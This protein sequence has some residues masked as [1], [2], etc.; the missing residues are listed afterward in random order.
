M[1]TRNAFSGFL[2]HEANQ[3]RSR[4]D[5]LPKSSEGWNTVQQSQSK[6]AFLKNLLR[7]FGFPLAAGAVMV[8]AFFLLQAQVVKEIR[9]GTYQILMDAARQ[10]SNELERYVD[11][12]TTRVHLIASYD[13]DTGPNTLVE[14]LR[15]E[16]GNEVKN[17]G[18][19][20]A[21]STGYLLYSDQEDRFVGAEDWFVDSLAGQTTVST[22]TQN[23]LDG[24]LGVRVST[25]VVTQAGTEGVL[26]ATLGNQNFSDLLRTLAYEG[27][28]NTF[29]SDEN[30]VILF[31]EN[32]MSMVHVGERIRSYI[33]DSAL[34]NGVTFDQLKEQLMEGKIV[35]FHFKAS[36][37]IYYA[38]CERIVAYNWYV[39]TLVPGGIADAI[40]WRVSEYQIIMLLII[41]LVGAT[42]ATQSYRHE[43]ETVAKL[44]ADKDLL[45]Q[46]AQRY[47]LIT[48]LSN[49]VFFHVL[50]DTG[51]IS[52]NDTFESMFGFPA[53]ACSID[54]PEG[55]EKLFFEGDKEIFLRLINHL[56]A[57]G[58]EAHVELR[59]INSRG[60]VRWKRVEI[61]A[62][63]D[64]EKKAVQLV[65]KIADIHRQKQSIQRLIRK[66]DSDPLTGLLNRGAMER[67]IK[68]F[69]AGEGSR[70]N[71]ALFMMDFDN[72]KSVN[73]TLGHAKGD[74]LLTQFANGMRRLFRSGDFLSRIGGDEYMI[75]IK[76]ARDDQIILDKAEELRSEMVTLSRKIGIPVSISVGIAV[77]D[78]DGNTFET[79]Y[80]HADKALYQVKR[81]GKNA[82]AFASVQSEPQE[83]IL[84]HQQSEGGAP[85]SGETGSKQAD[86]QL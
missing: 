43:R 50:L 40:A 13:A 77:Y 55:C 64:Q 71:H 82:I 31:V 10:Q 23:A 8:L 53:P 74:Q 18:V 5:T 57:G 42:M 12:L 17:V 27:S 21:N 59:M 72:F 81:A 38:V 16:L 47:Q 30:G 86:H 3:P 66:A 9:K 35:P 25:Y 75:F 58:E 52:F 60:V 4:R 11:M 67:E 46:S 14:T 6:R 54:R 62:V 1:L 76:S 79:L 85:A 73:D 28:A 29:V 65:G 19:G 80:K 69:L 24:L 84:Q 2:Q 37:Q 39:I 15:T 32:G 51:M 68:A 33:N 63:L 83:T 70:G 61:F 34:G 78:R 41:L 44:E 20:Y 49:E 22:D 56:R 7:Y 45:R 26:F 48:R 36:N